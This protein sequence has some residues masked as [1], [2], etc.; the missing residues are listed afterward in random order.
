M[1]VKSLSPEVAPLLITW[2]FRFSGLTYTGQIWFTFLSGEWTFGFLASRKACFAGCRLRN[3][4][5]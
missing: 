4:G 2:T 1:P 5:V 3:F